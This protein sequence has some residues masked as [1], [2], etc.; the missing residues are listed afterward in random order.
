MPH[1]FYNFISHL[2]CSSQTPP[3][4]LTTRDLLITNNSSIHNSMIPKKKKFLKKNTKNF[5]KSWR[6]KKPKIKPR[7]WKADNP[8]TT[9]SKKPDPKTKQKLSKALK[10]ALTNPLSKIRSNLKSSTG[11]KKNL[12]L[13]CLCSMKPNTGADNF[14]PL[15]KTSFSS[16]KTQ[17]FSSGFKTISYTFQKSQILTCKLTWPSF[18]TFPLM[19]SQPG[20]WRWK[21]SSVLFKKTDLKVFS[22]SW[23]QSSFP[24]SWIKVHGLITSKNNSSLN[25]INSWSQSLNL[26]TKKKDTLNSTFQSKTSPWEM[27][28]T[29]TSSKDYKLSS[30]SGIV[31]SKKL[32]RIL[33]HTTKIKIPDLWKKFSTG[34]IEEKISNTLM[35]N[36]KMKNWKESWDFWRKTKATMPK[37]L[38]NLQRISKANH[39]KPQTTL[40]SLNPS[41]NHANSWKNQSQNKSPTCFQ[42]HSKESGWFGSIQNTTIQAKEFPA[43]CAKFPTK[44]SRDA[45]PKLTLMIC[46]MEMF[47]IACRISTMPFSVEK[48]GDKFM[49]ESLKLSTKNQA[50][51]GILAR[52]QSLLLSKPSFKDALNWSKFVKANFN[53]P[54]KEETLLYLSLEDQKLQKLLEFCSKSKDHSENWFKSSRIIKR[55][56]SWT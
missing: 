38:D 23:T 21:C 24:A 6:K 41:P 35:N 43:F 42:K 47:K 8:L 51:N 7:A 17:N 12:N 40:F 53:S 19:F 49:T 36:F 10:P 5:S 15:S 9:L 48:G 30:S 3:P 32:F 18:T 55:T 45:R 50:K 37:D 31:K 39:K 28:K 4:K 34:E 29:K 13:P 1:Y 25:S 14:K 56:K 20:T 46:S 27:A 33:I 52:I 2:T 16:K 26:A 11:S 22:L 54:W 44:S